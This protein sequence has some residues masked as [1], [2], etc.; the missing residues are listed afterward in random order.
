MLNNDT[1]RNR[2]CHF[3]ADYI[4][5]AANPLAN[6]I[7]RSS[8]YFGIVVAVLVPLLLPLSIADICFVPHAG[9]YDLGPQHKTIS[10]LVEELLNLD[11]IK[12]LQIVQTLNIFSIEFIGLQC[13]Y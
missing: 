13:K 5:G 7:T 2:I 12:S 10:A 1:S 3:F 4:S 6:D 8:T 9:P 11:N